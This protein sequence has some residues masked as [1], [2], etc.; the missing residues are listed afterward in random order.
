MNRPSWILL[1]AL[2]ASPLAA[3]TLP[4]L[5]PDQQATV[6]QAAADWQRGHAPYLDELRRLSAEG[7]DEGDLEQF[8]RLRG[9]LLR[10]ATGPV[11][12]ELGIQVSPEGMDSGQA[13]QL[14]GE[15]MQRLPA[16]LDL[17]GAGAPAGLEGLLP[18]LEGAAPGGAPGWLLPAE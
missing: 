4:S 17:G 18:A 15:L 9:E 11:L 7:D 5:T 13:F 8:L 3:Q 2:L 1:V 14:I 6:D 12:G 16:G 10:S